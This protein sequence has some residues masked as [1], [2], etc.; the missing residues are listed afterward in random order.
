ME[1]IE[2][3][4]VEINNLTADSNNSEVEIFNPTVDPLSRLLVDLSDA[5]K[6][7][8][9]TLAED[10]L[11]S[12]SVSGLL[13]KPEINARVRSEM[14]NLAAK[15]NQLTEVNFLRKFFSSS[16]QKL[17]HML[18]SAII[19][20]DEASVIA[21]LDNDFVPLLNCFERHSLAT[22]CFSMNKTIRERILKLLIA[23]GLG[24]Q[25]KKIF[26]MNTLL[27]AFLFSIAK[28]EDQ[29]LVSITKIL[30]NSGESV[31]K[32][33]TMGLNALHLAIE[34]KNKD[35]IKFLIEDTDVDI[36][37]K[38]TAGFTPLHFGAMFFRDQ[39]D[40]IELMIQKGADLHSKNHV[41]QTPYH[42]AK[43]FH[44]KD[45]ATCLLA[46][47]AEDIENPY[48]KDDK[49]LTKLFSN[50]RRGNIFFSL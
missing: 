14:L 11:S 21:L 38:S 46:H 35:L 25:V 16:E 30:I 5:I 19:N 47:G 27:N 20:N 8:N 13:S 23:K 49:I 45:V 42:L 31:N 2:D 10:L 7:K 17:H 28:M 39:P 3:R 37:A 18:K 24:E 43:Q 40:V 41:G 48:K 6:N 29:D 32:K 22:A 33:N 44:N 36:N 26:D 12:A 1:N 15:C 4:T 50:E 9:L 34:V